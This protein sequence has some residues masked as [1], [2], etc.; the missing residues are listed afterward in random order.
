MEIRCSV[1]A[2]Y[3]PNEINL[4]NVCTIISYLIFIFNFYLKLFF[5][6]NILSFFLILYR[7]VS[8]IVSS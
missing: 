2:I 3:G 7:S 1:F 6:L 5:V 8:K 4:S